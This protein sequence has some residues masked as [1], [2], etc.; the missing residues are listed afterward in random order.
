[1]EEQD[2][3]KLTYNAKKAF[4]QDIQDKSNFIK[5]FPTHIEAMELIASSLH[6]PGISKGPFDKLFYLT[7]IVFQE[8]WEWIFSHFP[9]QIREKQ[10]DR[11]LNSQDVLEAMGKYEHVVYL[12]R[13]TKLSSSWWDIFENL[14]IR[15]MAEL[16][17][18]AILIEA[19]VK[20]EYRK[21]KIIADYIQ[22]PDRRGEL[23]DEIGKI[24]QSEAKRKKRRKLYDDEYPE[25]DYIYRAYMLLQKKGKYDGLQRLYDGS[26]KNYI[27]KSARFFSD[28]E[29]KYHHHTEMHLWERDLPKSNK[30][31]KKGEHSPPS[32]LLTLDG[33]ADNSFLTEQLYELVFDPQAELIQK[34]KKNQIYNT[35]KGTA[36]I[37]KILKNEIEENQT[38]KEFCRQLKISERTYY[39]HKEQIRNTPALEKFLRN[40]Q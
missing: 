33:E 4:S 10:L 6:S 19:Y 29:K 40:L 20:P 1:L 30:K 38:V 26:L 16:A 21:N 35:A 28:E 17:L 36:L 27:A 11:C 2:L 18:A 5:K 22:F 13:A 23:N 14:S 3:I 15:V 9:T 24:L 37:V 34:E 12:Y 32:T 31:N 25:E 39:R 8:Y 7:E